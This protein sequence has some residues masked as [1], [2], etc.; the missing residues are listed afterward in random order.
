M[1]N[2]LFF[3]LSFFLLL[4]LVLLI[5]EEAMRLY[6]KQLEID[7]P[8]WLAS[9]DVLPGQEQ[10]DARGFG[11][12]LIEAK[13]SKTRPLPRYE[14]GS[15]YLGNAIFVV[16]GK[17]SGRYLNDCWCFDLKTQSW[18][19][20]EWKQVDRSN[21]TVLPSL[22][23][24][25]YLHLG[26]SKCVVVGG[27]TNPDNRSA[28]YM[29]V[30]EV[31]LASMEV[32]EC[33]AFGDN[34]PTARGGHSSVLLA[35]SQQVF[36]FGG[37]ETNT[38]KLMGD[39]H[40]YDLHS[41]TWTKAATKGEPPCARSAHS[42]AV[43]NDDKY[44]VVFGGGSVSRC[45]DDV[46]VLDTQNMEWFS[47]EIST[48]VEPDPRAGHASVLLGTQWYIVGG[49]NNESACTDAY[50]LDLSK[51][52]Q[53]TVS[54]TFVDE[55]SPDLQLSCEGASLVEASSSGNKAI[56]FGGYNG[57]YLNRMCSL[58]FSSM[59]LAQSANGTAAVPVPET[60]AS[61]QPVVEKK[62]V[63]AE[64]KEEEAEKKGDE[65]EEQSHSVKSLMKYVGSLKRELSDVKE[66]LKQENLKCTYLE[67]ENSELRQKMANMEKIGF[68]VREEEVDVQDQGEESPQEIEREEVQVQQQEEDEEQ[69]EQVTQ[70]SS[71][72]GFW[73]YI[74]GSS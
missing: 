72:G 6:V 21:M 56:A 60:A 46:F 2:L 48:E 42:V 13:L 4:L 57:K 12:E 47:P 38:K 16:G 25:S 73:G 29:K 24:A 71:S 23:S 31:D 51:L 37:E 20:K 45:F 62:K 5:R 10:D 1:S 74:T 22:A 39:L 3:F 61:A 40:I 7:V 18:S 15:V 59:D 11:C 44:M 30:Y 32:A 34:I 41:S 63:E 53:R 64:K 54:W 43:V 27:H 50:A 36:V 28:K 69:E 14:H 55:L 68:R 49:G 65:E 9:L 70:S 66:K 58:H 67:I 19:Q 17:C 35:R 26:G 8:D 52:D 33:N